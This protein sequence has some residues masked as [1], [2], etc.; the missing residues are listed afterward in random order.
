MDSAPAK[1]ITV[2]YMDNIIMMTPGKQKMYIE[3]G[4]K[5]TTGAQYQSQKEQVCLHEAEYPISG[6]PYRH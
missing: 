2:D 3:E 6:P 5:V 1:I 4:S